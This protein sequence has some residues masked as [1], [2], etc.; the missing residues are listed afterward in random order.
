MALVLAATVVL[1]TTTQRE[2][3]RE[4]DLA[5]TQGSDWDGA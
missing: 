2:G 3:W 4:D 1:R 5:D